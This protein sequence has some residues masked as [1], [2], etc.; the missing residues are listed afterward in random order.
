MLL[1]TKSKNE[2][3]GLN[4]IKQK[5]WKSYYKGVSRGE[6][7]LIKLSKKSFERVLYR[8]DKKHLIQDLKFLKNNQQ[9]S[10]VKKGALTI[11]RDR[12]KLESFKRNQPIFKQGEQANNIYI[13]KEGQFS[14]SKKVMQN[15]SQLNEASLIHQNTENILRFNKNSNQETGMKFDSEI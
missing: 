8:I 1:A 5:N 14:L 10:E 3:F 15:K 12:L 9:L 6:C 7:H 11:L 4:F 2:Y 13:I